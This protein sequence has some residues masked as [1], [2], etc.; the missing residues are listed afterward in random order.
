MTPFIIKKHNN[1]IRYAQQSDNFLYM[2]RE[3][4]SRTFILIRKKKI[5]DDLR[6]FICE[7]VKLKYLLPSRFQL[8]DT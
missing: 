6:T 4:T 2:D 5:L 7:F 1:L 8:P 3:Q